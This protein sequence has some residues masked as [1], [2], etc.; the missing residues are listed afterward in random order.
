[1]KDFAGIVGLQADALERALAERVESRCREL[2]RDADRRADEL[3]SGSRRKL[4]ERVRA[5][6]AEERQRRDAALR[7]ARN[8]VLAARSRSRHELYAGLIRNGNGLLR[9]ALTERWRAEGSRRSWCLKLLAEARECFPSGGWTIEHPADWTGE[10]AAWL[11]RQLEAAGVD[12][13]ACRAVPDLGCGLRMRRGTACLDG[14]LDGLLA[15]RLRVEGELLAAW[16]R[17]QGGD[18]D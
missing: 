13:A 1:M 18:H 9:D 16:E 15:D 6:V 12:R 10:D 2:R 3:V 4:R 8:R 17:D 7:Q 11:G 14:S 5:A